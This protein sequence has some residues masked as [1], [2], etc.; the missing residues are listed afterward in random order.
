MSEG[1]LKLVVDRDALTVGDMEDL[2]N[3]S[4]LSDLLTWISTHAQ[5]DRAALRKLPARDL[6]ALGEHLRA[7]ID[8]ALSIPNAT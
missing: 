6:R 7:E 3:A 2:E 4:K 1:T 8:A 5:V